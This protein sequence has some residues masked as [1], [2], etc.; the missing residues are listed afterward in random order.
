MIRHAKN[1]EAFLAL[2]GTE[3]KLEPDA[4]VIADAD[5][6]VALAGVMGGENSQVTDQTR[7][8]ALESAFFDPVCVRQASKKYGLRSDSSYRFEREVDIETVIAAQSRAALLIQELAGGEILNGRIDL[9]PHPRPRVDVEFRI[10]RTNQMLG[11]DL[12]ADTIL[13]IL[14]AMGLKVVQESKPGESYR[15]EIPSM[16]PLLKREIDL[17]EEVARLH[18][19]DRIG[20][21]HPRGTL[22][23]VAWT[24]TQ[25][26]IRECKKLLCHL[27]YSEAV[28]YSFVEE[29]PA[30]V[31][32]SAFAPDNSKCIPLDN[33]ISSDM[34]VM[35]TS[36][37]PGLVK[38]AVTNFNKGQKSVRLFEEGNA[39]FQTGSK[40][41]SEQIPVLSVIVAGPHPESVWSQT[42]T[43]HDYYDVKGALESILQAAGCDAEYR[44]S[45]KSFLDSAQSVDCY[46][47]KE[48]LAYCGPLNNQAARSLGLEFPVY[49]LEIHMEPLAAVGDKT[50]RFQPLPKYPETYRDISILVDKSVDSKAISDLI[51]DSSG[52]LLH[53]VELYDQFEG[54]KLESGKKSLTFALA[55][56]SPEKTLTDEEVNPVFDS[57]V[58]AL[59]E[60]LGATLRQ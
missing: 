36:L 50:P 37:L 28:N 3:L 20:V 25:K 60:Q 30:Q 13:G 48:F 54:K 40:G 18:G 45:Q 16:Y 43:P 15:L 51:C 9:Y 14:K 12:S 42:G 56:Q 47:G 7:T 10:S 6:P 34:N 49:V 33:P 55:F 58:K 19:Y 44:P 1:G 39:F 22:S 46:A 5:K 35:R 29:G 57:I 23:P 4:L 2:D 41:E 53:R 24:P 17:I 11:T 32:I 38:S 59:S 52:P 21:S 26:M 8:V 31:F 27:G